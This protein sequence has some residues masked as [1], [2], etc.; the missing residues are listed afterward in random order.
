ML[1]TLHIENPV[2]NALEVVN[3]NDAGSSCVVHIAPIYATVLDSYVIFSSVLLYTAPPSTSGKSTLTAKAAQ[4]Q[5]EFARRTTED[6]EDEY[7]TTATTTKTITTLTVT[8]NGEA[9]VGDYVHVESAGTESFDDETKHH[10]EM[11][12]SEMSK[13]GFYSNARFKDSVEEYEA[14]TAVSFEGLVGLVATEPL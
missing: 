3:I 12:K 13:M 7:E 14:F 11:L 10:Y 6:W 2:P 8:V 1:S 5:R 9:E 4:C